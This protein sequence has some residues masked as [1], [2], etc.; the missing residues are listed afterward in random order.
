MLQFKRDEN[1]YD[2]IPIY[3]YA[4]NEESK[5]L[6]APMD[7][8]AAK[9]EVVIGRHSMPAEKE[10]KTRIQSGVNGLMITG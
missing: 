6:Y 9:C 2:I 3:I 4:N 7:T 5:N 1:Y 10:E 8:A